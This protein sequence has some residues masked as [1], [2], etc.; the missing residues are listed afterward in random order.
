ME[1]SQHNLILLLGGRVKF[2]PL[3]STQ[4][5][6]FSKSFLTAL[7]VAAYCYS[8]VAGMETSQR[9]LIYCWEGESNFSPYNLSPDFVFF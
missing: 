3:F 5:L 4:I 7:K 1:T 6:P 8:G 2:R 9:N